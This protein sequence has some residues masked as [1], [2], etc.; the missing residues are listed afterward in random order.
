MEW[1]S[2]LNLMEVTRFTGKVGVRASHG[3]A[4]QQG[5]GRHGLWLS[6]LSVFSK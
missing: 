6:V 3:E 4:G 5:A 1:G 2:F